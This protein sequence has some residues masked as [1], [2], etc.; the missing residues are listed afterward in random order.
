MAHVQLDPKFANVIDT[1]SDYVVLVTPEGDCRGLYVTNRTPVSFDV[2]ELEGGRASVGFAY[3][4]VAKR[5]G[6]SAS[7]LPMSDVR[8]FA[9]PPRPRQSHRLKIGG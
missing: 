8:P 2:R 1:K 7:R 6:V 9:T 3:R 5:F 4:I